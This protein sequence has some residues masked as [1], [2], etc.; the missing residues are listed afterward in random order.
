MNCGQDGVVLFWY[1]RD[2]LT[3]SVSNCIF[4]SQLANWKLTEACIGSAISLGQQYYRTKSMLNTYLL[5]ILRL[6]YQENYDFDT[7]APD[8]TVSH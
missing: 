2:K 8:N 5:V 4:F 3:E 7:A 1:K 6:Q